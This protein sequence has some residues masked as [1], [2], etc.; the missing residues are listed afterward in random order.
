MPRVGPVV[1]DIE[2]AAERP[3]VI[4]EGEQAV[5]H[6]VHRAG[7]E[8]L[9]RKVFVGDGGVRHRGLV[10]EERGA[11]QCLP[12]AQQVAEVIGERV[13]GRRA[14]SGAR[15][16][17]RRRRR[18]SSPPASRRP[19]PRVPRAQPSTYFGQ[20]VLITH[21]CTK[22]AEIGVQPRAAAAAMPFESGMIAV[23]TIGGCGRWNGLSIAP[24]PRSG[25]QVRS[26]VRRHSRPPGGT[27][28]PASTARSC[29]RSTR[30]RARY[31]RH[32]AFA[33]ISASDRRPAGSDA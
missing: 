31:G 33:V 19:S 14:S 8:E 16:R 20:C 23:T 12:L 10:L 2:Q 13:P 27:A 15:S 24:C 32:R 21:G 1:A 30:Q 18:C 26:V 6:F 4:A 5:G 9:R 17:R 29:A 7:N 11:A 22:L 3:D 28:A 25:I